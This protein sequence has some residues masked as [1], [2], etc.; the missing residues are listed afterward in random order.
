MCMVNR[1]HFITIKFFA[2][3]NREGGTRARAYGGS[4]P[5]YSLLAPP[6]C[7]SRQ[8]IAPLGRTWSAMPPMFAPANRTKAKTTTTDEN[9][10][11]CSVTNNR[12]QQKALCNLTV[13]VV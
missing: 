12:T 3:G 13:F 2:G 6:M 10:T 7:C 1:G 11:A 5:P 9:I 4:C 8:R